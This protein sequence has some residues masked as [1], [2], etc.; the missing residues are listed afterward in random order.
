MAAGVPAGA[1]SPLA[2]AA[3]G[4]CF[5]AAGPS[6]LPFCSPKKVDDARAET[7]ANMDFLGLVAA[8]TAR[9]RAADAL[10]AFDSALGERLREGDLRINCR[11]PFSAGGGVSSLSRLLDG[12]DPCTP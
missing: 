2:S 7:A 12:S 3:T 4:D 5:R 6:R 1:L 10:R 11:A 8:A 9:R